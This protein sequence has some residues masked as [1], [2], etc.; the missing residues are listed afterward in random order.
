MTLKTNRRTFINQS[1]WAALGAALG[2]F[3]QWGKSMPTSAPRQQAEVIVIG[4][5]AAGLGAARTLQAEDYDVI[6][7]EARDRIGGRVWTSRVWPDTPLDLGASWIHG[8]RGNPLAELAK[9]FK[10]KTVPTDYDNIVTYQ[11]TGQALTEPERNKVDRRLANILKETAAIAEEVEPD[12]SLG[13]AIAQAR[14]KLNLSAR[15]EREL[16]YA[17]NSTIE[18][19]FAADVADLSLY[20]WDEG[21]TFGGGDVIFPGG[22]GQILQGLAQD[23]D[24]RLG[25][26]VSKIEYSDAGVR[27][28]TA[29]GLFEAEYAVITLPLGVL[30]QGRVTFSPVLPGDKLAAIGRLRMGLLNKLYLRFPDVFWAEENHLLGYISQQRGQW[31][32]WLNLYPLLDQPI[33]LA[34]N[35]GS[36][37]RRLEKLSD[38][39][40]V[41]AAL[42]VLKTIYGPKIPQPEAWL[43]SRWVNDPLAGGSYSYLPPGATPADRETL[44]QAVAERLFFAG[45]A[46]SVAYPA[47]VHGAYL[48]GLAVAEEI[49]AL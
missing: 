16:D 44:A 21:E 43:I 7:L 37:G 18:H 4:A 15:E 26:T 31:A 12:N 13:W 6:V 23:L 39:A 41:E 14:A 19:E 27:V 22:Y 40:Q 34:F 1:S 3:S 36:Y 32:E 42:E 25:H 24:I 5:G 47:T 20:Y 10:V 49:M 9:E 29:Q 2:G 46:T 8:V 28:T 33:L 30:Q 17:I 35:A 38:A 45:E 48:S 11:P